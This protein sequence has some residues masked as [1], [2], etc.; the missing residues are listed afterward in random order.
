MMQSSDGPIRVLVVD[1][2]ALMR[3]LISDTLSTSNDIQVVGT[4]RDGADALSKVGSL[5][6]DIMTLDIQMPVMDGLQVLERLKAN[7]IPA[8]VVSTLTHHGAEATL[9]ALQ[10]GACDYLAKPTGAAAARGQF[11]EELTEKIRI[12]G[13]KSKLKCVS[14]K[15]REASRGLTEGYT[16]SAQ[17]AKGKGAS[18]LVP[19]HLLGKCIAI[20]VS[21]GG[22]P[23]LTEL[24]QLLRPPVAGIVVVQHMPAAFTGSFAKRL[25]QQS[26]LEIKEA[27]EGD[28]VL[29]NSVLIAPGGRH[30][31]L[32]R[33]G[34]A[35]RVRLTD[36]SPV[37]SHRP[38]VDIMMTDAAGLYR[39]D[40]LGVI[41]TGMGHDGVAGCQAIKANGGYVL[42]QNQES[43]A[44]YGMNKLAFNAGYVDREVDI[45]ELASLLQSYFEKHS[46]QGKPVLVK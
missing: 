14:E 45:P 8:I 27:S 44:V 43:S 13:R 1:D 40:L 18:S 34:G 36:E 6:P 2:S 46:V 41:L 26:E 42:G 35:V 10:L 3:H 7:P 11:C 38:S 20:G 37:S 17:T 39:R 15:K 22:P 24:F 16:P 23:V 32:V 21:T 4:A 33:S 5:K 9:Q 29:P 12:F 31:H 28:A 30:L 19:N 25:S